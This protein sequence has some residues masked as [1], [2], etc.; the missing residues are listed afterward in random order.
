MNTKVLLNREAPYP[1]ESI[2]GYMIRLSQ[3]N[4]TTT[5]KLYKTCDLN[6]GVDPKSLLMTSGKVDISKLVELTQVSQ[7]KLLKSTFFYECGQYEN[8][9]EKILNHNAKLGMCSFSFCQVCPACLA[10]NSY[11][12]K[13]WEIRL[14]TVCYIHQ[15]R[16]IFNCP[17]CKKYLSPIRR[18]ITHCK[19]K[20]DLRKHQAEQVAGSETLLAKSIFDKMNT[21]QIV[22]PLVSSKISFRYF[23][24]LLSHF[25]YYNAQIISSNTN[26]NYSKAYQPIHLHEAA[27]RTFQIFD[28]WPQSYH[29]FIDK[30]R[31]LPK[32]GVKNGNVL[33]RELGSYHR[34]LVNYLNNREHSFVIEE[35]LNYC[36]L[37]F[38][39]AP[40]LKKLKKKLN[41]IYKRKKKSVS[42]WASI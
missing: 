2:R 36:E 28:N 31:T 8:E 27:M 6:S 23:L 22:S 32:L 16:M 41:Q 12:R 42:I 33:L 19:C 5:R 20:F 10:E 30:Y 11:H 26:I 39:D 37:N 17:R 3:A 25:T 35:F 34:Y 29:A 7:E 24:Y 4:G 38:N 18:F 21:P 13:H 14:V 9:N 15:C 1:D 40:Y